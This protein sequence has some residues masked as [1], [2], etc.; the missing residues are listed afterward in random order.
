MRMKC[1]LSSARGPDWSSELLWTLPFFVYNHI[2]TLSYLWRTG[3]SAPQDVE[4]AEAFWGWRSGRFEE[5]EGEGSD[6]ILDGENQARAAA[7]ELLLA[8]VQ[9]TLQRFLWGAAAPFAVRAPAR[10]SRCVPSTAGRPISCDGGVAKHEGQVAV[11]TEEVRV[12][13]PQLLVVLKTHPHLE[14]EGRDGEHGGDTHTH[15]HT[16]THRCRTHRCVVNRWLTSTGQ[17]LIRG[18]MDLE[19]KREQETFT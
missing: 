11:V 7:Q 16:H 4:R 12:V 15:T 6:V 14:H 3:R 9:L 8:G 5:K 10:P 1:S 19:K 17:R 2:S 18:T 13:V